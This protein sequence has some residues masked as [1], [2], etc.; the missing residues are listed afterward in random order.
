MRMQKETERK[1]SGLTPNLNFAQ[2]KVE[3][4]TLLEKVLFVLD[5]CNVLKGI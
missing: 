2:S 3:K 4:S 1:E 5:V